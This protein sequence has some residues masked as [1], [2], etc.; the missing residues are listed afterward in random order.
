[1]YRAVFGDF[2]RWEGT[3]TKQS[4]EQ[5]K[6]RYA[7]CKTTESEYTID[8]NKY[9]IVRHFAD[10]EHLTREILRLARNRADGDFGLNK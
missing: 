1:M 9:V 3:K 10:T 8:G 7:D 6:A 4:L 2:L 5:L